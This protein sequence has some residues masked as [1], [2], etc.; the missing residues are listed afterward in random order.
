MVV[1]SFVVR[2]RIGKSRDVV[3]GN[4]SRSKSV[5]RNLENLL[6]GEAQLA[7]PLRKVEAAPVG[8]SANQEAHKLIS[9]CQAHRSGRSGA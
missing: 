3:V 6:L 7:P 4:M 2:E 5:D 8:L 1:G 9:S